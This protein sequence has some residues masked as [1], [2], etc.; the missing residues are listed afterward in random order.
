MPNQNQLISIPI[1]YC[2]LSD[3]K[4]KKNCEMLNCAHRVFCYKAQC[5]LKTINNRIDAPHRWLGSFHKTD[6]TFPLTI[7]TAKSR[8]KQLNISTNGKK[9]CECAFYWGAREWKM[10]KKAIIARQLI[11]SSTSLDRHSSLILTS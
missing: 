3:E 6:L 9:Q 4:E 11:T 5:S 1:C 8:L 7:N 2:C 10:R